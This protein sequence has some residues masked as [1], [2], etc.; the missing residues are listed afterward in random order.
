MYHVGKHLIVSYG[1]TDISVKNKED[2][3]IRRTW[4]ETFTKVCNDNITNRPA[5]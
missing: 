4:G 3:E 5:P 2:L 1:I